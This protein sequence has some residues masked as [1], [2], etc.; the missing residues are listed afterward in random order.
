VSTGPEHWHETYPTC[1]GRSQS[2][3]NL[4]NAERKAYDEL[5]FN[6]YDLT[7][8]DPFTSTFTLTNTGQTGNCI[9]KLAWLKLLH[10]LKLSSGMI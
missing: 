10:E 3:V 9:T 2:P 7:A 8:T 4:V 6:N 1:G 5:V